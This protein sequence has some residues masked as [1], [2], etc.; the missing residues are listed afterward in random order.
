ME[1]SKN[2]LKSKLLLFA[3]LLVFTSRIKSQTISAEFNYQPN[4]IEVFGSRMHYVDEYNSN[5][6]DQPVF[7]FLHG[8]PTSSYLWRNVIPYVK[9]YGRAIA[10]DLIGMGK[11]DK[12]NINYTLE[13]HAKYLDEFI[14]KM[15]LKN[16]VLVIHDW[17][18]ALGFNYAKNHEDN[19]KGIVF[20]EAV[21]QPMKWDDFNP[22]TKMIFKMMRNKEKGHKMNAVKNKFIKSM[23]FK[24]GTVRKF[25]KEEKLHYLEP[26]PTVESRKP[27]E[28]WPQEIP[29][30]GTPERNFAIINAYAE[31]LKT[32][33]LPKL[34][35]Y[36]KPGMIIKAKQ[37]KRIQTDYKNLTSVYTGKGK[38]FLQEDHPH[39]IGKAIQ[40]WFT[41]GYK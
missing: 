23:L 19:I 25:T 7:L 37:L 28:V 4:Y 11:S 12:P 24:V 9:P 13:D 32:T 15:N 10:V 21:T 34:L 8:N 35:I 5:N 22:M 30:D 16:I 20:M 36:G 29:I 1:N 40:N 17:G 6:A 31:W 18:S 33:T 2:K 38:H 3:F 27:L 41:N 14:K 26:Y 39:E